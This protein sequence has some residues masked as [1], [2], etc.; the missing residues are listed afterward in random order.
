VVAE[1]RAGVFITLEG[2]EG[3]GKSTN[4]AFIAEFL[5]GQGVDL[6]LTREPGGT[7]LAEEI[8][9]LLLA[10][11]AE[12]VAPMAELLLIFAAR[13]QHLQQVIWP[14]LA[15]GRWVLCDRF[16][17]AT[18]AYQACA[19]DLGG[20]RVA[21]LE[22][23]VQGSFRPDFTLLLDVPVATGLARASSRGEFDRFEAEQQAFF[24]RVRRGYLERVAMEP[25]RYCVI[26]AAG[27]LGAVQDQLRRALAALV[28]RARGGR[29]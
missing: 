2:G 26:D 19:R 16:T 29:R 7:P 4:M 20:A 5:R 14:A 1:A 21:A 3:S 8:R 15:A 23:L 13:A 18:Y 11:R 25:G 22:S 28:L 6:L 17:D 27:A 12:A 24:E 10:P 9:Q